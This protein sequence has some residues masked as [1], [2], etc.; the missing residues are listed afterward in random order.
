[1]LQGIRPLAL[2]FASAVPLSESFRNARQFNPVEERDGA[3]VSV[4]GWGLSN[5]LYGDKTVAYED[6]LLTTPSTGRTVDLNVT[7]SEGCPNREVTLCLISPNKGGKADPVEGICAGDSGG[8]V[9]HGLRASNPIQVGINSYAHRPCAF[10]GLTQK[11]TRVSRLRS[12]IDTV[13]DQWDF[14]ESALKLEAGTKPQTRAAI[15]PLMAGSI[16]G[17]SIQPG[18]LVCTFCYLQTV[19]LKVEATG[20]DRTL[21]LASFGADYF[22]DVVLAVFEG[23]PISAARRPPIVA[24]DDVNPHSFDAQLRL[25]LTANKAYW[26]QVSFRALKRGVKELLR[27]PT[28]FRGGFG[29]FRLQWK[30]GRG[31]VNIMPWEMCVVGDGKL[32]LE[33]RE[34]LF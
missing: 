34:P 1:M 13:A 5:F 7:D 25:G 23:E 11:V 24:C 20:F 21:T 4:A 33:F 18:E 2:A 26:V 14:W 6:D 8:P 3:V 28:D 17:A 22:Q 10:K 9:V 27:F 16:A 32:P 15:S 31:S 29:E 19:W 12:W 30:I